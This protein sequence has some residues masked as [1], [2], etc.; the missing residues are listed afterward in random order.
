M[1]TVMYYTAD[2]MLKSKRRIF[3]V[4]TLHS[5]PLILCSNTSEV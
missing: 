3:V 2:N 4:Y 1:P 5:N